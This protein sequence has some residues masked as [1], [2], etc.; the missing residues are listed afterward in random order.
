MPYNEYF[1]STSLNVVKVNF[2]KYSFISLGLNVKGIYEFIKL[3]Y[4][5][6]VLELLYF[7][8]SNLRNRLLPLNLQV[9]LKNLFNFKMDF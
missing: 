4:N 5:K 2:A 7:S 1:H 9:L 6:K 8:F 3:H